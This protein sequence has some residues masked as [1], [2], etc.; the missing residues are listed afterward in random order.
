MARAESWGRTRS[1]VLSRLLLVS[2]SLSSLSLALFLWQRLQ[3][4]IEEDTESGG[5]PRL[6][7][8]WRDEVLSDYTPAF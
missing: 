8:Y 6:S 2:L 1:A 5:V 3:R 4:F 7:A